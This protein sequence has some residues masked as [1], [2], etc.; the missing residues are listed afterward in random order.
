MIDQDSR[1]DTKKFV[2]F[3]QKSDIAFFGGVPDSLLKEFCACVNYW[4]DSSSHYV[5]A[6]EGSAVA[7]GIGHHLGS[8]GVPLIYMQN[9]GLGNAVNPLVSLADTE[10]YSIPMILIIG[11]RGELVED[12]SQLKDEPQHIKQGRITLD[13]LDVMDIPYRILSKTTDLALDQMNA[14]IRLAKKDS[15]PVAAVVRR[16]SFSSFATELVPQF[17][18]APSREA[19][20]NK[21]ISIIPP[22]TT[23]VATTGMT[24]RELFELRKARGESHQHDFLTVG[25]M[26]HA[27][28]IAAGIASSRPASRVICL[29]GDGALVMHMGGLLQTVRKHNLVHIVLNNGCHDSVG[30]QKTLV[31]NL[32]LSSFAGSCGFSHS[33]RVSTLDELGTTLEQFM[34]KLDRSCFLEALCSPGSRADLGR[35]SV[36]P[37]NN[38]IMFQKYMKQS[39]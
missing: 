26:G 13:L 8:G 34:S 38:K 33:A 11:W 31:G 25:G 15:K 32:S 23:I 4:V 22:D 17:P 9:S 39:S 24:S 28:Q 20:I 14:L 37:S 7:A 12:G 3:L 18:D 5:A 2:S 10:V 16:N 19:V 36:S 29:D 6:N 30:S 27:S 21:I 1:I 35:P